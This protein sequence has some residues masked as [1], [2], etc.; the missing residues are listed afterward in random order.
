MRL[1]DLP[2]NPNDRTLRQFAGLWV[3]FF[4]GLAA[5]RLWT[6][7][8]TW[9]PVL[10]GVALAGVLGV[11]WPKLAK[12][13]F[14]GWTVAVFPIAWVVSHVVLAAMYFGLFAPL[15][16]VFRL[17]GRDA[18]RRRACPVGETFWTERPEVTDVKRYLR[19]F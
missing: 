11:V 14:V 12:P 5:W 16:L 4:A 1:A 10:A 17:T 8:P 9:V 7:D 19:Q 18:L 13:V 6:N 3:A 2:L 15:A